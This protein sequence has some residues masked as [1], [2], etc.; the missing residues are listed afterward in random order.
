VGAEEERRSVARRREA[1]VEV[2]GVRA[3]ARAR[4]VL[5]DVEPEPAEVG[6]DAVGRGPLGAGRSRERGQLD[7]NFASFSNFGPLY[8]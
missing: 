7:E 5:V 2:A 3:D 6:G 8:C 1:G 4:V